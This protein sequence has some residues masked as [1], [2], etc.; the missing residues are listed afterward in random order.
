MFS[1]RHKVLKKGTKVM[2]ILRKYT[3]VF[4]S[5]VFYIFSIAPFPV[6]VQIC[7]TTKIDSVFQ[8]MLKS[9]FKKQTN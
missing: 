6:C 4:I 7:R 8:L 5:G 3:L 2:K 9:A 1:G